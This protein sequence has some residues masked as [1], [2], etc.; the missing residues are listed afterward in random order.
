[1]GMDLMTNIHQTCNFCCYYCNVGCCSCCKCCACCL[2]RNC[3]GRCCCAEL[4]GVCGRHCCPMQISVFPIF[5]VCSV[6]SSV[7]AIVNRIYHSRMELMLYLLLNALCT[8]LATVIEFIFTYQY[9]ISNTKTIDDYSFFYFIEIEICI[10]LWTIQIIDS[11]RNY[12]N[13]LYWIIVLLLYSYLMLLLYTTINV[14]GGHWSTEYAVDTLSIIQS[15]LIFLI[16]FIGYKGSIDINYWL[17]S[18]RSIILISLLIVVVAWVNNVYKVWIF[19]IILVQYINLHVTDFIVSN[20]FMIPKQYQHLNTKRKIHFHSM[21]AYLPYHKSKEMQLFGQGLDSEEEKAYNKCANGCIN[22]FRGI[23][24]LDEDNQSCY[25]CNICCK[26]WCYI[27]CSISNKYN[28][29]ASTDEHNKDQAKLVNKS[30]FNVNIQWNQI[31]YTKL[32]L[33]VMKYYET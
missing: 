28:D 22:F 19:S 2:C 10:F 7:A 29:D 11:I 12:T 26:F 20:S 32:N 16:L 31:N 6:I 21:G 30:L 8:L 1:M 4:T 5:N 18:G 17:Y 27:Y 33:D 13:D 23:C 25:C 3:C 14:Y 9:L 24:C 15:I